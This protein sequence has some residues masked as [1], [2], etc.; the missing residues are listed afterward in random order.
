M[1]DGPDRTSVAALTPEVVGALR[2]AVPSVAERTVTA[3]TEEVGAFAGALDPQMRANIERAVEMALTTFWSSVTATDQVEP[4]T[5]MGEAV[6]AA[7]RLGRGEARSGRTV[8]TLLAAYRIGARVSWREMSATMV[9][10]DLPASTVAR[11]AELVF[12]YVDELSATSVAG[13]ADA[14]AKAGRTREQERERLGE[15]LLSGR[16]PDVLHALA[17]QAEWA[18]PTTLT[19]VVLPSAQ[20]RGARS[21][22]DHRTLAVAA[23]LAAPDASDDLAV[24]LV[25]DAHRA[26]AEL[27]SSLRGRG[28]AVGPTRPWAEVSISHRR[29]RRSLALLPAPDV[30][31]LDVDAHLVELVLGADPEALADLRDLV[32]A[33]LA[34][35]PP[36]TAERLEETLRSWLLHQGRREAVAADL[37][38]HPQTVRYRMAQVRERYGDRLKDRRTAL[39]L[40]VALA[41]PPRA[42]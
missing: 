40:T 42:S 12:A 7:Y 34:G 3:L 13:H 10:H 19:A 22:L 8:D 25:P 29:A 21:L 30:E 36:A 27:L 39:E 26:R 24:L 4:G 32:L 1:D 41:M 35:L 18:P 28:A 37:H 17:E 14:L 9:A 33:P 20:L 15:A 16:G 2:A 11:F 38:L 23:D 6:G 5:P 31:P